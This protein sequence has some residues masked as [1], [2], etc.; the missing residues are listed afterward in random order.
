MKKNVKER[1]EGGKDLERELQVSRR[2]EVLE[3]GGTRKRRRV[4]EDWVMTEGVGRGRGGG[5]VEVAVGVRW[6]WLLAKV[7]RAAGSAG[8]RFEG[9]EGTVKCWM[10]GMAAA[11]GRS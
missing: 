7:M 5:G 11:R 6:R 1:R 4:V 9:L 10:A 3:G 2:E 8:T